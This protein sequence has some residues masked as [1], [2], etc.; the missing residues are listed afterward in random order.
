[1]F[2]FFGYT[3]RNVAK[4]FLENKM[5]IYINVLFIKSCFSINTASSKQEPIVEEILNQVGVELHSSKKTPLPRKRAKTPAAVIAARKMLELE[6]DLV[7][8]VVNITT[9]PSYPAPDSI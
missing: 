2:S 4:G 3:V 9:Y 1:M 8:A 6:L 5:K 7:V